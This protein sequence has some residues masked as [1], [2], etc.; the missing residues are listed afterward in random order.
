MRVAAYLVEVPEGI[1]VKGHGESREK[2]WVRHDLLERHLAEGRDSAQV[3]SILDV[4]Y[5][6]LG[7]LRQTGDP[8]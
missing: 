5:N 3:K 4:V 8:V 1:K 6:A 7:C 2:Q